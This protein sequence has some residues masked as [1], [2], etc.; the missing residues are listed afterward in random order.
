MCEA[1]GV[2][3]DNVLVFN[4]CVAVCYPLRQ[5]AGWLTG[6]LADMSAR[7]VELA[8]GVCKSHG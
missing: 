3:D 7:G 4:I 8:I 1:E 2:P 6:G 5:T